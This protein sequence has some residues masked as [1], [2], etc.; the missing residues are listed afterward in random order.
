[1]LQLTM[2][3]NEGECKQKYD[4]SAD[5]FELCM[6][7]TNY[8]MC[9]LLIECGADINKIKGDFSVFSRAVYGDNIEL[10]SLL[11]SKNVNFE[12]KIKY[13]NGSVVTIIKYVID[14][15]KV[16]FAEIILKYAKKKKIEF[17]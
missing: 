6:N 15:H 7:D 13:G 4:L 14:S 2:N 16:K 12:G 9:K 17:V 10:V 3:T 8:K 1:M 11:I 5:L